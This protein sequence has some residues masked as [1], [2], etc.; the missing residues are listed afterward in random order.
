MD[1]SDDT[2]IAG[3]FIRLIAAD[4]TVVEASFTTPAGTFSLTAPR[5]GRY[6]VRMERIGYGD[7][8]SEAWDLAAGRTATL[9]AAVDANPV[10]LE[11]LTVRVVRSCLDDPA[12]GDAFAT[13]WD[14]ARKALETA[15]WAEGRGE[16]VFSLTEYERVLDAESL[17]LR[18]ATTRHRERVR[19]PPFESRPAEELAAAGYARI[20]RD[21]AVFYAPDANVLLSGTFRD[22]H[23]FG[24]VREETDEGPQVGITF[25]PRASGDV[26]EIEGTIWLDER[27]AELRRATFAYRNIALPRGTDR[28]QVGGELQF[29]RLPLGPFFVRDWWIRFPVSGRMHTFFPASFG[30]DPTRIVL[31][32]YNQTGGTVTDATAG[33]ASVL[34]TGG[35]EVRGSV[36]DG[37]AGGPLVGAQVVLRDWDA[38]ADFAPVLEGPALGR[39]AI[40]DDGGVFRIQGVPDGVYAA[41]VE[42]PRLAAA[43]VPPPAQ[44]VIVEGGVAESLAITTPDEETLYARMCP[45]ASPERL[46]GAIA[47]FLRQDETGVA[48]AGRRVASRWVRK[49]LEGS[50]G[51]VTVHEQPNAIETRSRR[52]GGFVLCGVP[53]GEDVVLSVPGTDTSVGLILETRVTWRN[54]LVPP[55]DPAPMETVTPAPTASRSAVDWRSSRP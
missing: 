50:G 44:R 30:S 1:A 27:S 21:S 6:H 13:V 35:G 26:I 10:S 41:V 33:G 52:G 15:V 46:S 31:A 42:H 45:G 29:A 25:E 28:R 9:R 34:L 48:V 38:A 19:L 39:A 17:A 3:A 32:G 55:P 2:P 11:Q 43:G 53:I 51:T 40:T 37:A 14:E 7:W 16:L 20:E 5:P 36:L 24:L 23:C 49:R 54:L 18:G 8:T 12:D 22:T 47:G 4:G